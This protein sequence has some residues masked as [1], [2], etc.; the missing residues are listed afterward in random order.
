MTSI[1]VE[2]AEEPGVVVLGAGNQPQVGLE[3]A[4]SLSDTDGGVNSESW[5]WQSSSSETGPWNDVVGAGS[6]SYTTQKGDIDRHLRAVVAYRDGH[7]TGQDTAYATSGLP[8]R[9]DPNRPA[10]FLDSLT[11]TFNIS[12]NVREGVRVTP[13]FPDCP[14]PPRRL[15]SDDIC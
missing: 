12:I 3:L 4:A 5:Q 9:P 13:P 7:E 11:T 8:V 15:V 10:A 2:N 6:A 14:R 1:T